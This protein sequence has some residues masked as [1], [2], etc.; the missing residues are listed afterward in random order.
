MI[1]DVAK[2]CL[3]AVA[4][5]LISGPRVAREL[6]A[7]IAWRGKP[8][9]I[10]S[11]HGT[12]F[13]SNAMLAWVREHRIAWHFIAP[14]KPTQNGI[15]EAFNGRIRTNCSNETIFSISI[16]PDR[17]WS[18]GPPRTI[19]SAPHSALG[20]LT[21][22]NS[23]EPSPQRGDRLSAPDRL[24]RSPIAPPALLRQSQSGDSSPD[25]MNARGDSSA[26]TPEI[27]GAAQQQG[28]QQRE[29]S[30]ARPRAEQARLRA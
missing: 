16:T 8:D 23:R 10:I 18:D 29:W 28:G 3:A 9:L 25:W 14:G 11:D 26:T 6:D 7:F 24:R 20:Y 1:D 13:I 15:C 12:E 22:R 2:E 27:T 21:P 30:L 17:R 4:D 5:A 19:R